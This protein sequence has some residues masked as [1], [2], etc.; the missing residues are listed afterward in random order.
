MRDVEHDRS[1][2]DRSTAASAPPPSARRDLVALGCSVR[3]SIRRIGASSS[4]TRTEAVTALRVAPA[5]ARAVGCL[6]GIEKPRRAGLLVS[7]PVSR[8]LSR[9]TIPLCSY[10]GPRRAASAGPVRLAPDGVWLAAA[11]PRR[12]W[13]LTPPF[14]PYR[15]P[16]RRARRR[17][18]P[19]CSTFRRLSPPGLAPASCPTVS[20]LSSKR[21]RSGAPRSPGLQRGF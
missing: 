7:R 12:W 18:C 6:D 16:T 11:S 17:R 13:A 2:A 10:P 20:G 21:R 1:G 14:H 19:F 15:R 9:V 5:R 8:I 3:S 4:T